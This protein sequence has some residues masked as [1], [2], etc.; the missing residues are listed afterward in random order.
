MTS[1]TQLG[2]ISTYADPDVWIRSA[3]DQRSLYY[4]M[5][6]VYVDDILCISKDT[7]SIMDQ[8]AQTYRLKEG[9][10]QLPERYLGANI[11]KWTF[12]DGRHL[13][14]MSA[15][16]Y[17]K[18]AIENIESKD[19]FN[20]KLRTGAHRPMK[21]DY[22]PE[23]DVTPIL[24][25]TLAS[26]FQGLI[27]VLRWTCEL[28]R[29]DILP[30]VSMLSSHNALPREG[31]LEAALDIVAYLKKHQSAAI[32]FDDDVPVID[33][34]R[35]K[36]VDWSDIYGNVEE[37]LPPNMP[38]PLGNPVEMFC[39]VDSD[40]AGNLAT[41]RSHSGIIIFLNKSPILWYS[42]RQ[43]TVE[44]STFGSEFVAL[45]SKNHRVLGRVVL[46]CDILVISHRH[47]VGVSVFQRAIV[48]AIFVR[49][50]Y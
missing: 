10:V 5:V 34:R 6:L 38:A 35:F 28:G 11:E 48:R 46:R 16:S 12:Q 17:I 27:G 43:N 13:W 50:K 30:E 9:S 21:A 39:F 36:Q 41:R 25:T 3:V 4:E 2:F 24:P 44:S 22:C 31:H 29:V 15:K 7:K 32:V 1:S 23:I 19:E 40:H 14:S 45:L 20:H 42:K 49:A 47:S 18:S 33:E 26:Y 37:A 8:I